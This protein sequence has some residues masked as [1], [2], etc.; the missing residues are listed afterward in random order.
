MVA[1]LAAALIG[2]PVL[3]ALMARRKG[4]SFAPFFVFALFCT[5]PAIITAMILRDRNAAPA[6]PAPP[7][8]SEPLRRPDVPH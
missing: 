3:V 6:P 2:I 8:R 7:A 1:L 5:L 4:Y